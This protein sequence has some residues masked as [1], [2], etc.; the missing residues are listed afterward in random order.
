MCSLTAVVTISHLH[1]LLSISR[2]WWPVRTQYEKW[3]TGA[4]GCSAAAQVRS[5]YSLPLSR[6]RLHPVL[7]QRRLT[8]KIPTD[9]TAVLIPLLYCTA[10][11][12]DTFVVVFYGAIISYGRGPAAAA[13][14]GGGHRMRGRDARQPLKIL[15][16]VALIALRRRPIILICII[17]R[18]VFVDCTKLIHT[19]VSSCHSWAIEWY[20]PNVDT[21]KYLEWSFI[22]HSANKIHIVNVWKHADDTVAAKVHL[23][24]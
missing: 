20:Q 15:T 1:S 24:G 4:V 18:R 8:A 23:L 12:T 3:I 19:W 7:G 2:L 10:S 9:N 22:S 16:D 6:A 17:W 11:P 14:G 13:A 21:V 5:T